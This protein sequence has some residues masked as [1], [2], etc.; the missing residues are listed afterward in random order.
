VMGLRVEI[1]ELRQSI[2]SAADEAKPALQLTMDA[3]VRELT[4]ALIERKTARLH[5][6]KLR[7]RANRIRGKLNTDSS[8]LNSLESADYYPLKPILDSL[9]SFKKNLNPLLRISNEI[10]NK[11][12]F[13]SK[14]DAETSAK[15][16]IVDRHIPMNDTISEE[17]LRNSKIMSCSYRDEQRKNEQAAIKAGTHTGP[18]VW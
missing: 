7:R 9:N 13:Q 2:D 10:P 11:K 15:E 17:D 6:E 18:E 5:K 8:G 1:D 16:L 3:K 14:N 12:G 4:E